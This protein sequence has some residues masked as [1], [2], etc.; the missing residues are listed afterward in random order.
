MEI[1][2]YGVKGANLGSGFDSPDYFISQIIEKGDKILTESKMHNFTGQMQ[3]LSVYPYEKGVVYKID[4]R[5]SS[6]NYNNNTEATIIVSG[7]NISF[8]VTGIDKTYNSDQNMQSLVEANKKVESDIINGLGKAYAADKVGN[9]QKSDNKFIGMVETRL[10]QA[11]RTNYT[12][13]VSKS[14]ETL[15]EAHKQLEAEE[16]MNVTPYQKIAKDAL[17]NWNGLSEEEANNKI[18]TESVEQLEGQVYAMGSVGHAVTG[19]AQNLGLTEVERNE[20]YNAVING[21]VNAPIFASVSAK[22]A[23]VE[24]PNQ[25]TLSVLSTIHDGWVVDNSSDKTYQKKVDRGQLRQYA[26]LELIGWNEAKS[27]LLFL[28]PVLNSI[29]VPLN[30]EQLE[31]A[32]H[33]KVSSYASEMKITDFES[34]NALVAEGKN[35]YPVLPEKKKKKLVANSQV[36]TRQIIENWNN[37]DPKSLQAIGQSMNIDN[38]EGMHR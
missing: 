35:Y 6:D 36:V 20:F 16:S 21:P 32:Y 3:H 4:N 8:I 5:D 12:N 34:L 17:M 22:A 2:Y 31:K 26:P 30:E 37:K 19:I 25:L 23:Q 28:G 27:D 24:D 33:D 14:M 11:Q 38:V 29:N 15:K 9:Y 1:K 10:E 18:K 13:V 7:N